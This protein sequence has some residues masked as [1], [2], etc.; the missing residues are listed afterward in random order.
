MRIAPRDTRPRIVQTA[1]RS[2][3]RR[4][5]TPRWLLL[6]RTKAVQCSVFLKVDS[7]GSTQRCTA[8]ALHVPCE[9]KARSEFLPIRFPHIDHWFSGIVS[10]IGLN[11]SRISS[12]DESRRRIHK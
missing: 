2:D 6:C 11:E 1:S 5:R 12:V 10:V 4:A 9:T 3:Q 8:V 7:I